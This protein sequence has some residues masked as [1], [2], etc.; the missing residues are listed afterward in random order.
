MKAVSQMDPDRVKHLEMIQ[1][2]VNRLSSNSF[3]YKAWAIALVSALFALAASTSNP[4]YL[5]VATIP[6]LAF[7]GLDAY[8]LLQERHFRSLYDAIRVMSD[9]EWR[10]NPFTMDTRPYRGPG[11]TWVRVVLSRTVL[12]LYLPVLLAVLLVTALGFAG[13]FW[14]SDTSVCVPVAGQGAFCAQL[15]T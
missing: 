13:V 15:M 12:W 2:V 11:N 9:D 4:A 10:M 14:S 5:L 6:T 3:A 1:G 8:Y 7:W